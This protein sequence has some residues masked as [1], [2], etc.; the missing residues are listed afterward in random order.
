MGR[1]EF[2]RYGKVA[3]FSS[4]PRVGQ[5]LGF[6]LL[7]PSERIISSD[8]PVPI[9]RGIVLQSDSSPRAVCAYSPVS[10]LP[11]SDSIGQLVIALPALRVLETATASIMVATFIPG[12]AQLISTNP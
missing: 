12:S 2:G 5:S 9:Y 8:Y 3:C 11:P 6:P 10:S 4:K 1:P 7:L